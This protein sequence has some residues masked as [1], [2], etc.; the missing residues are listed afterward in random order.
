MVIL[1]GTGIDP[2]QKML[3]TEAQ[4]R[5]QIAGSEKL[6]EAIVAKSPRAE[7]RSLDDASHL[8]IPMARPDAVA[9][10]INDLIDRA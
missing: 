10:A 1:S 2:A 3:A 5:G 7:H 9:A 8:T 6:Y 4:L